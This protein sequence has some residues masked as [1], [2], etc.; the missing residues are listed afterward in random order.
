MPGSVHRYLRP[1]ARSTQLRRRITFRCGRVSRG[2]GAGGLHVRARRLDRV[3]QWV[4]DSRAVAEP[5]PKHER[6]RC[7]R[8]CSAVISW[9]G[10]VGLDGPDLSFGHTAARGV[11]LG[12]FADTWPEWAARDLR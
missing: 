6:Q 5:A 12:W 10:R 4:C 11:Q 3:T 2:P 9:A 1:R 7:Q 8:G